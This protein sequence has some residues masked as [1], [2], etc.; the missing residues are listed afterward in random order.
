MVLDEFCKS[1]QKGKIPKYEKYQP[2]SVDE[3]PSSSTLISLSI[4]KD[5]DNQAMAF[6]GSARVSIGFMQT[7][8]E[9]LTEPGDIILIGLWERAV[10]FWLE[11]FQEGL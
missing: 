1:T 7:V 4:P 2:L 3:D 5:S 11:I 8:I 10:V 6:A 9:L